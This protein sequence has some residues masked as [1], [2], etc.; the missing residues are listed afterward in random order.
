[1]S[2]GVVI[3]SENSVDS[4]AGGHYIAAARFAQVKEAYGWPNADSP[5]TQKTS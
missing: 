4:C 5:T 1:M 2:H 3:T